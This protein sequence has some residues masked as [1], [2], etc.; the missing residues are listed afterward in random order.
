MLRFGSIVLFLLLMNGCGSQK[1][2]VYPVS[3]IVPHPYQAPALEQL[4]KAEYIHAVNQ[5]RAIPRRCGNKFY[6]AGK[7]LKW[8]DKLYRAAYE[9]SKDMALCKHFSHDGSGTQSDWTATAQ[10]LG[11][12]STFV[13]RI[14]NSGYH[15]YKSVAENIAYGAGSVEEVMQ[16]WIR[17]EGHCKNI[18]NHDFT[19]FGMAQFSLGN[20]RYYWTQNFGAAQ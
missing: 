19:E 15:R 9:H 6:D 5:M 18:M 4:K 8:N 16:Q 14:E 13:N 12:C 10:N 20:G 7:P 1:H 3:N 11:R 2:G 17:S